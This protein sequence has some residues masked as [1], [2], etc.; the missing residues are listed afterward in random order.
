MRD[1]RLPGDLPGAPLVKPVWEKKGGG[2]GFPVIKLLLFF[3]VGRTGGPRGGGESRGGS[4]NSRR[5]WT[6]AALASPIRQ[7][8]GGESPR[9]LGLK[10]LIE[11]TQD[12]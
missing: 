12:S 4:A 6:S 10:L 1:F 2:G 3:E 9:E 7:D 8:Q 11:R 5:G